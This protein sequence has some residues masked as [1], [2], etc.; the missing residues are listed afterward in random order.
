MGLGREPETTVEA[1]TGAV[2]GRCA[3]ARPRRRRK[4]RGRAASGMLLWDGK[5]ATFL[6]GHRAAGCG[7]RCRGQGWDDMQ[8]CLEGKERTKGEGTLPVQSLCP[9]SLGSEQG[10]GCG[11]LLGRLSLRSVN[12]TWGPCGR[13]LVTL[14]LSH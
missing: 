14:N 13:P 5:K 6:Q 10:V 1:E 11:H 9:P 3:G 12:R 4:G 7:Y 2:R 8:L